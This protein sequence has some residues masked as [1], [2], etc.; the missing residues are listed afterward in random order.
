MNEIKEEEFFS[1]EKNEGKI[2]QSQ[3]NGIQEQSPCWM[4]KYLKIV[5]PILLLINFSVFYHL[6]LKTCPV[7]PMD[8][9][10]CLGW[11][12]YELNK[13]VTYAIISSW[14]IAVLLLLILR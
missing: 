2:I 6:S 11:I 7:K 5:F 3:N 9:N 4:L 10:K 8:I 13:L 14:S 1:L 12:T